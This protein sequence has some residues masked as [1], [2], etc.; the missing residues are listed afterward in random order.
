MT[1]TSKIFLGNVIVALLTAILCVWFIKDIEILFL[2]MPHLVS[3]AFGYSQDF[4]NFVIATVAILAAILVVRGLQ[5]FIFNNF[6]IPFFRHIPLPHGT[7][8]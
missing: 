2:T 3:S 6:L 1:S 4:G 5:Q 7:E 8:Y